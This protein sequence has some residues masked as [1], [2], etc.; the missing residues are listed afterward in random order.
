MLIRWFVFISLI[1]FHQNIFSRAESIEREF[2]ENSVIATNE[3]KHDGDGSGRLQISNSEYKTH[4]PITENLLED[5]LMANAAVP[6]ISMA[7][8]KPTGN[9]DDGVDLMERTKRHS[10]SLDDIYEY[11][12][13]PTV[14]RARKN[15]VSNERRDELIAL[16]TSNEV[17]ENNGGDSN[18]HEDGMRGIMGELKASKH[19]KL[20]RSDIRQLAKKA[21]ILATLKKLKEKSGGPT[22]KTGFTDKKNVTP[23]KANKK[24]KKSK[25]TKKR[26]H[27]EKHKETDVTTATTSSAL[28]LPVKD[29][30][31]SE[32][33][34]HTSKKSSDSLSDDDPALKATDN[35]NDISKKSSISRIDD[36]VANMFDDSDTTSKPTSTERSTLPSGSQLVDKVKSLKEFLSKADAS[37]IPVKF[38]PDLP[39]G[40]RMIGWKEM[41]EKKKKQLNEL[42]ATVGTVE[43]ASETKPL[44]LNIDVEDPLTTKIS[45]SEIGGEMPDLTADKKSNDPVS[46]QHIGYLQRHIKGAQSLRKL[47]AKTLVGHCKSTG[48]RIFD[49]FVAMDKA[50]A[51]AQTIATVIGKKFNIDMDKIDGLVGDKEDQVIETF[52]KD[53][54]TKI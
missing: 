17:D 26:H 47:I 54:F 29:N 28:V 23:A 1:A 27:T 14:A 22:T 11:I 19:H 20:T 25:K 18:E 7:T 35:E 49:A 2:D 13:K 8:I 30:E 53:I 10:P 16:E 52:L 32:D 46:L 12:S 38:L 15:F 31:M 4:S 24:H 37:I 3:A 40:L 33:L 41:I 34:A 44:S 48:K 43:D 9:E 21:V 50:L 45:S 42:E 39:S 36:S 6:A 51:R 5:D